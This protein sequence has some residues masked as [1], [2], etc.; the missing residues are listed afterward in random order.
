MVKNG[1]VIGLFV[2]GHALVR[3]TKWAKT[4]VAV[5]FTEREA[6][7]LAIFFRGIHSLTVEARNFGV[8]GFVEHGHF[9]FAAPTPECLHC[10]LFDASKRVLV[11]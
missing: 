4:L 1:E 6:E 2:A 9:G 7:P 11:Y 8:L 5:E 3:F 10:G